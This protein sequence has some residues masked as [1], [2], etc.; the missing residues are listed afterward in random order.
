MEPSHLKL[1]EWLK[2]SQN[3]NLKY[4]CPK[5]DSNDSKNEQF[6][7]DRICIMIDGSGSTNNNGRSSGSRGGY[8]VNSSVNSD[9]KQSTNIIILAELEGVAY[10]LAELCKKYNLSGVKIVVKTFGNAVYTGLSEHTIT[11]NSEIIELIKN[12]PSYVLCDFGGTATLPCAKELFDSNDTVST[13]LIIA[14]DG[15]PNVG[16]NCDDVLLYFSKLQLKDRILNIV[17]IG[18][19][20]IQQCTSSGSI[21]FSRGS[22]SQ[23]R[24]NVTGNSSECN[25]PFMTSLVGYSSIAGVY[26]PACTDYSELI[27]GTKKFLDGIHTVQYS[28]IIG[29]KLVNYDNPMQI[30]NC[31]SNKF[32]YFMQKSFGNYCILQSP[33]MNIY[34]LKLLDHPTNKCSFDSVYSL[35]TSDQC[36]FIDT[37][38]PTI[39]YCVVFADPKVFDNFIKHQ[40]C[41]TNVKLLKQMQYHVY[42]LYPN[43]DA[44]IYDLFPDTTGIPCCRRVIKQ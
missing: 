34:Q 3:S 38:L 20:S 32:G 26:L 1:S 24:P 7:Y 8:S 21:V 14:T 10:F 22:C 30:T 33:E 37:I 39:N 18:A 36:I 11:N 28:V 12:F 23:Q 43:K 25:V 41:S 17:A 27:A 4:Y 2:S 40:L 42:V 15:Q 44:Y 35:M 6:G 16:G 29:K 31:I 19:G 5:I 13:L 9:A